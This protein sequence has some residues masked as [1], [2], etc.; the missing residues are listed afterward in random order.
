M[1]MISTLIKSIPPHNLVDPGDYVNLSTCKPGQNTPEPGQVG[2]NRRYPAGIPGLMRFRLSM[3]FWHPVP[4]GL[5][6]DSPV[7]CSNVS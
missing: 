6:I 3:G 5:I 4:Y 1:V 2:Q 7:P